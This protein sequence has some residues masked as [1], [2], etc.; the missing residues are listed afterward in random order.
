MKS[1]LLGSAVCVV[2]LVAGLAAPAYASP[3]AGLIQAATSPNCSL[4]HNSALLNSQFVNGATVTGDW[5][6][7]TWVICSGNVGDIA[8]AGLVDL[9]GQRVD[10]AFTGFTGL[11]HANKF[12]VPVHHCAPCTGT[13]TM[14]FGQILQSP[15]G[16]AWGTPGPGCITL[17]KGLYLLCV[18]QQTFTIA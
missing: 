4:N 13:W 16:F 10:S 3:R 12:L 17:S 11:P 7:Y 6:Y 14:S 9:N 2:V 15:A 18:E 5:Y 1:R 8:L